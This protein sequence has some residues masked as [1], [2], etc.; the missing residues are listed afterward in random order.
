MCCQ[1]CLIFYWHS[2]HHIGTQS[3]QPQQSICISCSYRLHA[4]Y[5]MPCL[6]VLSSLHNTGV[7]PQVH[8]NGTHFRTAPWPLNKALSPLQLD[9]NDC[10][11]IQPKSH[12]LLLLSMTQ[13]YVRNV[14]K[15]GKTQDA[16]FQTYTTD[17]LGSS[18]IHA[19]I[20]HFFQSYIRILWNNQVT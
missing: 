15:V 6:T 17:H 13:Q 18:V 7:T 19:L 1:P 3:E 2:C 20:I 14:C 9:S 10:V 12:F 11:K 8:E 5:I 4:P 16:Q